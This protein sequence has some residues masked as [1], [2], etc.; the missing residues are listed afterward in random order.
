MWSIPSGGLL[1]LEY[2]LPGALLCII[3][4]FKLLHIVDFL[5]TGH[6]DLL[7]RGS[8]V[9]WTLKANLSRQKY[10]NCQ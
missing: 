5:Y 2:F 7:Y 1:L 6:L 10:R 9:C 3:V 8:A 4:F